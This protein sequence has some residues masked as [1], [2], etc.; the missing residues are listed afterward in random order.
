M[1]TWNR[2]AASILEDKPSALPLS[3]GF[4]RVDFRVIFAF[5]L[6]TGDVSLDIQTIAPRLLVIHS[7]SSLQRVLTKDY[8][9]RILDGNPPL[10]KDPAGT[11]MLKAG[12]QRR[13]GWVAALGLEPSYAQKDMF[14]PYYYDCVQYVDQKYGDKRG[15]VFWRSMD[16]VRCILVNVVAKAF[17]QDATAMRDIEIATQA[18]EYIRTHETESGIEHFFD[19][20]RPNQPLQPW[21]TAKIIKL[22]NGPPLIAATQESSFRAEWISL[23]HWVLI[24]AVMGSQRCITYFKNPGKELDHILPMD[25][26]RTAELY[27]RG[28]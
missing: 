15:R 6:M 23:L 20:P 26:L 19:I 10:I 2:G 9:E 16:R 28:C 21:E 13:G 27:I 5:L 18:L 24:A 12:D 17:T 3:R 8:V 25:S 7:K 14:M 1:N 4:V 22:F 11:I